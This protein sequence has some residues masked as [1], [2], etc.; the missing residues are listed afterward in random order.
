[1]YLQFWNQS[2]LPISEFLFYSSL[3]ERFTKLFFKI[4]HEPSN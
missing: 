1:M 3:I 4:N 2:F